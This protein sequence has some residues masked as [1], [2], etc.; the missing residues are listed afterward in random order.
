[1][2]YLVIRQHQLMDAGVHSFHVEAKHGGLLI[3]G[4]DQQLVES[5][6]VGSDNIASIFIQVCIMVKAVTTYLF[7][8]GYINA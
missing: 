7:V 8:R 5:I 3:L 6:S 4:R 1:M 2:D